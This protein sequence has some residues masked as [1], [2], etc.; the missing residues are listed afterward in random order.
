MEGLSVSRG[1]IPHVNPI[2]VNVG[3]PPPFFFL[4]YDDVPT[5]IRSDTVHATAIARGKSFYTYVGV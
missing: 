2:H 1:L 4:Y 3:T 5:N